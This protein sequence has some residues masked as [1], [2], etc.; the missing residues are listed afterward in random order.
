MTNVAIL[1][2][3]RNMKRMT[4]DLVDRIHATCNRQATPYT[5]FSIDADS[6]PEE[7][8]EEGTDV[9]VRL[10]S[11]LRW[12]SAFSNAIAVAQ[13]MPD[14]ITQ[15]TL[16]FVARSGIGVDWRNGLAD[17]FTHFW[18]LC[19]DTQLEE[20]QD[21]LSILAHAVGIDMAQIHPYQHT[22]PKGHSQGAGTGEGARAESFVE[23]VC[24]LI[25]ADFVAAC[26]EYFG[27]TPVGAHFPYGWGVDYEMAYFAHKLGFKNYISETVGITHLHHEETE[28][29]D[30]NVMRVLA[31]NS[32]LDVL[33][34]RYGREWG[35]EFIQAAHMAGVSSM[36]FEEWSSHDRALAR[37]G[38][39]A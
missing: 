4:D 36:A 21:T 24:P 12:A 38:G 34:Q 16:Q 18:C 3:N 30:N 37:T 33:E 15:D 35:I 2:L 10:G 28:V 7:V 26:L 29:E 8:V 32:M 11:N 20:S 13:K 9:V 5:I 31:R 14:E 23:F 6:R 39:R 25:S 27:T 17:Q 22:Y 19:N 1:V